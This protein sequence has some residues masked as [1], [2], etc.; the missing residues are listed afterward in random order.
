MDIHVTPTLTLSKDDFSTN[1]IHRNELHDAFCIWTRL[2]ALTPRTGFETDPRDCFFDIAIQ[3]PT[4]DMIRSK[5]AAQVSGQ[6]GGCQ[7]VCNVIFSEQEVG[8]LGRGSAACNCKTNCF[9]P[10]D[11]QHPFHRHFELCV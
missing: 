3:Q 9:G 5:R 2:D 4:S 10:K 8:R 11:V 7:K 1:S 6:S